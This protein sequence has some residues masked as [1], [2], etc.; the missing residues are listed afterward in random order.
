LH[1]TKPFQ[2]LF[3]VID[4]IFLFIIS[5]PLTPVPKPLTM[6]VVGCRGGGPT[7]LANRMQAGQRTLSV[8]L[9][10]HKPPTKA[11]VI[12]YKESLSRLI[13]QAFFNPHLQD[14]G[15]GEVLIIN[16]KSSRLLISL[17]TR[18]SFNLDILIRH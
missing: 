15:N 1:F 12:D 10:L 2:G 6:S 16:E 5:F 18:I 9:P 3:I 14:S 17:V 13:R 11:V 7:P 4:F 8:V